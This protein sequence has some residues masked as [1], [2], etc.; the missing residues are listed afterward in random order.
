[1][2]PTNAGSSYTRDT[3]FESASSDSH[4]RPS[5]SRSDTWSRML[6]LWGVRL[7]WWVNCS[8]MVKDGRTAHWYR[9]RCGPVSFSARGRMIERS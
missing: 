4:L 1:M 3:A 7:R 8:T 2:E 6:A 5:K 9:S